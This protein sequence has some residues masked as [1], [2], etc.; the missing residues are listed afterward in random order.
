RSCWRR[1]AP[2][3]TSAPRPAPSAADCY[4]V[5]DAGGGPIR[6]GDYGYAAHLDSDGDGVACEYLPRR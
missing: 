4:A 3:Q 6:R 2:A 5:R 1:F